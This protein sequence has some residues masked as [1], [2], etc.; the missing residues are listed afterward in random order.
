MLTEIW[1]QDDYLISTDKAKLDVE[2]IYSF[3]SNSYWGKEKTL[4]E[5]KISI[6]N[7]LCFGVYDNNI[8]IGFARIII[9]SILFAQ[10]LDVFI[11]PSYQGLGLG[12]WLINTIFNIP[13]LSKIK[14]WM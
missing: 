8:Q 12:K 10:L 1:Q 14:T 2:M 9:D 6:E 5:I 13:D 3:V 7:S 4:N 11:L